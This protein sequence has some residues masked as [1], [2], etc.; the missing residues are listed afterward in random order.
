MQNKYTK[1]LIIALAVAI[2][3]PQ[4]VLAAW[5]NPFS[6]G[7]WNRVFHFQGTEQKQEQQQNKEK[8]ADQTAGWKTYTNSEYGF[9]VK[10]PSA[11]FYEEYSWSKLS[12]AFGKG[13]AFCMMGEYSKK[14]CTVEPMMNTPAAPIFINTSIKP[15]NS[16]S[17]ILSEGASKYKDI[18][19]LMLSTFKFTNA[20]P[21]VGGDKDAHGCIGSAGYTWCE[22]KQKCLRSWEEKCEVSV[23]TFK[24]IAKTDSNK[25]YPDCSV[26]IYKNNALVKT[27]AVTNTYIEPSLFSVSPDRKYVAFKTAIYGGTCVYKAAPMVIDLSNYSFVPLD[28]SDINKEISSGLGLD[29]NKAIKFTA[30]QDI[31]AIKWLNNNTIEANMQFG[32]D[33]GCPIIYAGKT[34]NS[35]NQVNAEVKFQIKDSVLIKQDADVKTKLKLL[36]NYTSEYFIGD[37][38]SGWCYSSK[39]S[40]LRKAIINTYKNISVNC[41]CGTPDCINTVKWCVGAKLNYGGYYCTDS[42]AQ[43]IQSDNP[44]ICLNGVC[45]H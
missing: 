29:V 35:L 11:W 7:V 28:D 2:V 33:N 37:D 5:W 17:L 19:N 9:E 31:K 8:E 25:Q 34:N 21:V 44:N 22:A 12:G 30:T 27:V 42:G 24:A 32:D 13:I 40:N 45:Q 3:A 14:S 10:Y 41:S 4:M 6:W 18:Y 15:I 26:E 39:Y 20:Q 1:F 38:Q 23:Y 36:T 43:L 16:S